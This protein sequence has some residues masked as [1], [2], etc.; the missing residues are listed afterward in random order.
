MGTLSTDL[1]NRCALYAMQDV[2][3]SLGEIA[4]EPVLLRKIWCKI[5]PKSGKEIDAKAEI[6]VSEITH[7]ITMR[8]SSARGIRREMY[9]E[10]SG[11]K[12]DIS[13]VMPHYRERDRVVLYC[14]ERRA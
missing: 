12:L 13:Y 10:Y 4:H 8:A 7:E 6:S 5:T 2:E 11:Q 14:V 9:L 1:N 3:N